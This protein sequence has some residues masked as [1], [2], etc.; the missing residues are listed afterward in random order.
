MLMLSIT[1]P[2]ALVVAVVIAPLAFSL[3]CGGAWFGL[4]RS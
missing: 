4:D 2:V 1:E 3:A